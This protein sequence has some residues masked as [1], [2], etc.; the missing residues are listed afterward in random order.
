M[1]FH[2][3]GKEQNMIQRLLI[4]LLLL[5]GCA[6]GATEIS[7]IYGDG[8]RKKNQETYFVNAGGLKKHSVFLEK[9]A[10]G[11]VFRSPLSFLFREVP[12][13]ADTKYRLSF[14]ACQEGA[15]SME[16]NPGMA[17]KIFAHRENVFPV[18]RLQFFNRG[19]KRVPSDAAFFAIPFGKMKEHVFLFYAPPGAE[20]MRLSFSVPK[21]VS[22][23]LSDVRLREETEEKTLNINPRFELGPCNYSGISAFND[24]SGRLIADRNGR[25]LLFTGFYA[26]TNRFP[27]KSEGPYLLKV[28]GSGYYK[29]RVDSILTFYDAARKKTGASQMIRLT[30]QN[31]ETLVFRF[32]RPQDAAYASVTVYH[33]TISEIS[34]IREEEEKR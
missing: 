28:R 10:D 5:C 9:G 18:C 21:G 25:T 17:E 1:E 22:L 14:S 24:K 7:D 13:K 29:N 12:V 11:F 32:V 30:P 16:E 3:K 34:I 23:S 4:L 31:Q 26:V 15:E 20:S 8:F 2:C 27:L 6:G 33:A 19:K